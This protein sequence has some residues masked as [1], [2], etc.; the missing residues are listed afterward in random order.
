MLTGDAHLD[1]QGRRRRFLGFY[2]RFTP[3]VNA[4]MLPHHGSIHNHSDLVLGAMPAL[5]VGYAA[6]GPNDYGH[7]HPSVRDAVEG[8][9]RADF[10]RVSHKPRTRLVMDVKLG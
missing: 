6:A 1:R 9:G 8:H 3:L 4:L 7:P 10:H 5:H 2:R